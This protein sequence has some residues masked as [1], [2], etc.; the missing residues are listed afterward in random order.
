MSPSLSH[1]ARILLYNTHTHAIVNGMLSVRLACEWGGVWKQPWTSIRAKQR[2][3]MRVRAGTISAGDFSAV[4]TICDAVSMYHWSWGNV[5]QTLSYFEQCN[6]YNTLIFWDF[7]GARFS[8]LSWSTQ[9]RFALVRAP[10]GNPWNAC[11]PRRTGCSPDGA[12]TVT[13]STASAVP[14][15]WLWARQPNG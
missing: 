13:R 9:D 5:A 3:R 11:R 4:R 15:S 7:C 10:R 2:M 1:S 6:R 14:V 8:S 12:Q